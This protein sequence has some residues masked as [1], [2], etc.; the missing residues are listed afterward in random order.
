MTPAAP[1][2]PGAAAALK[3]ILKRE[4]SGYFAT[5]VAHVFTVVFLLL[6][7]LMAFA[8]E[9]GNLYGRGQADLQPFFLFHPWLYL[10]FAPA[11]S[12]R[13][14][15]EERR[16]GTLEIL[17]TLPVRT[18][19][20]VAGKFLAALAFLALGLLLTC[21]AWLTV[22]FLGEPDHGAI[23]CGYLGSLLLAGA[24]LAVGSLC[25]ALSRNQS[26]AF[27]LAVACCFLLMLS[28]LPFV[29][30]T[31]LGSA[32]GGLRDAVAG[33]SALTRFEAFSRGEAPLADAAYFLI[34]TVL[35]LIGCVHTLDSSRESQ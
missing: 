8:P 3:A 25:S 35:A 5:P 19:C 12:M 16:A 7:A 28:G 17:M 4:I 30:E 6:A 22:A 33:L 20:L 21:P 27:V 24:F 2:P 34:V 32:P 23:L 13:L 29:Q 10:F 9:L 18:G 15:S 31:L 11:L 1:T 26:V 14:W